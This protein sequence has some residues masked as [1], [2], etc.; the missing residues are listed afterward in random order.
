MFAE[1]SWTSSAHCLNHC[2]VFVAHSISTNEFRINVPV[3]IILVLK[4]GS[5]AAFLSH[6]GVGLTHPEGSVRLVLWH[7]GQGLDPRVS[8]HWQTACKNTRRPQCQGWL[9]AGLSWSTPV[10]CD[11]NWGCGPHQPTIKMPFILALWI[12]TFRRLIEMYKRDVQ[13]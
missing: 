9:P 11:S 5:A 12:W 10:W 1:M 2:L 13:L 3:F 6:P 8:L 4:F 7:P